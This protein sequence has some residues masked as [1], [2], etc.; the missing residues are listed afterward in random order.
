[1]T[2]RLTQHDVFPGEEPSRERGDQHSRLGWSGGG[3]GRLDLRD[4]GSG[5]LDDRG[6]SPSAPIPEPSSILMLGA[7]AALVGFAVRRK[8]A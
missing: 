1:M 6:G 4:V 2:D 3:S 7:G 5:P 8:L